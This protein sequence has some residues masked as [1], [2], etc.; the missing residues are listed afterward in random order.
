MG[1]PG[2][3]SPDCLESPTPDLCLWGQSLLRVALADRTWSQG[4]LGCLRA[5]LLEMPLLSTIIISPPL[6]T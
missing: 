2:T 3:V 4:W 5:I 1:T 6:F